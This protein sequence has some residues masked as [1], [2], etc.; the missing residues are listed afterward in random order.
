MYLFKI[1]YFLKSIFKMKSLYIIGKLI[2]LLENLKN[3]CT[4]FQC[5]IYNVNSY[6]VIYR[7]NYVYIVYY[8]QF[9]NFYE[10]FTICL[11]KKQ[12]LEELNLFANKSFNCKYEY[13]QI[14]FALIRF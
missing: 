11:N 10:K 2:Q 8:K 13:Q 4:D 14:N 7:I 6:C 3:I 12:I 5:V 1:M 9:L